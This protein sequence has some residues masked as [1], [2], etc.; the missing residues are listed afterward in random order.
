MLTIFYGPM[1]ALIVFIA[2]VVI[3][4]RATLSRDRRFR[5]AVGVEGATSQQRAEM[6]RKAQLFRHLLGYPLV[7]AVT[8]SWGCARRV[9]EVAHPNTTNPVWSVSIHLALALLQVW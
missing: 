3:R 9:Y 4:C 8:W 2:V 5:E 6:E 1:I 7:L